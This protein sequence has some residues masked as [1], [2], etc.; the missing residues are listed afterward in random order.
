M[1]QLLTIIAAIVLSP[2]FFAQDSVGPITWMPLSQKT[3]KQPV[4][5]STNTIDST[6]HYLADTLVPPFFDEFSTS[7]YQVYDA[8]YGDPN[9]TSELFYKL[10]DPSENPLPANTSLTSQITYHRTV[11]V[12]NNSVDDVNYTATPLRKGNMTSFPINYTLTN[13]YPPY[14][15]ID[16]IDF[17]NDP[18]TIW[19]EPDILQDS[20]RIFHVQLND[21]AAL[22]ID[23]HTYH[24][25]TMAIDP[26]SLG[27]ATFD[28]LDE[29]G[30]PYNFG[31][32]TSGVADFL[33]SKPIDLS[34]LGPVDSVY[35]SFL[36]QPGGFGELPETVDSLVLEFY[37][38]TADQ[39]NYIW[40]LKGNVNIDSFFIGHVPIR[41]EI[42]FTDAFQFRFKNYGGLSGSLDHFH[43]DYVHLR[44][45]SGYQDTIFSDFAW[46]YNIGSLVKDYTSVPWDHWKNNFTGKMNDEVHI[47]VHNS[48]FEAKNP[49]VSQTQ[50]L[51][52]GVNETTFTMNNAT[53]TAGDP[54]NDYNEY[55][56]VHS[57]H[58]F[59]AGY[60]FDE[61]APGDEVVFD[62]KGLATIQ[63]PNFPQNDT[64]YAQQVFSDYYAYDDGTAEKAY[65]VIGVQGRLAYQFNAY[66]AD[67]L[68]GVR[69]HFVPSVNDVS[70][71]LFLLTVW[72]DDGGEPGTVLYEDEFFFPRT[73]VYEPGFGQ[74]TTYYLADTMK[75]PVSGVFYV[76]WR[77]MDADRLNIGF[78]MNNQ[79][80][81][82][83]FFSVNGG[84]SWS[85]A[86]V[87]GSVMM[88]PVFSTAANA[89]LSVGEE[90]AMLPWEVYPNPTNGEVAIKWEHDVP[91]P[92]AVCRDA[93][94]RTISVIESGSTSL[95][96][97]LNGVP[98][99]LYFVE[100]AGPQRQVKKVVRY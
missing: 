89:D 15:V 7:K 72:G 70:D 31:S 96:M 47:V 94:G 91:F 88:R 86:T 63:A 90:E 8:D 84:V 48:F 13:G 26:W 23:H 55:R 6:F 17:P 19:I 16:T 22:W 46:S 20:A 10:T 2:F 11:D 41:T 18:D 33:T 43:L 52:S 24:N 45:E 58:D 5:S 76:G 40:G 50:V 39:W 51:L 95:K 98:A 92:G 82:K 59:S 12:A 1:K 74:F 57:Y 79:N 81:D 28:G 69:M 64:C 62:I 87:D 35:L 36:V 61:N 99:G 34:A 32:T 25:Y 97:D 71:K 85:N 56:T 30:V 93:Q 65:G 29:T 38:A 80:A 37:D 9:V 14:I 100:L 4:K 77:Q 67:S 78:D 54:E 49:L 53:M 27:V 42:Y 66:E 44:A 68:I 21:P 60:H 75:L 73:P 3:A 83:T